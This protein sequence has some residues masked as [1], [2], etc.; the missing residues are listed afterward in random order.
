MDFYKKVTLRAVFGMLFGI[1]M[2]ASPL[3]VVVAQQGT[4][5]PGS[6]QGTYNPGSPQGTYNGDSQTLQNPLGVSSFC[7]LI[8]IILNAALIIGIPIAILFIVFAGAKF[9]L[10]R[11]NP[12]ELE[13]A[14]TNLF[15]TLIGI[16]I[17]VGASLI[18]KVII[19]TL[20][21]LGVNVGSCFGS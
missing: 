13:A 20:H 3:F 19:G 11:G 21:E 4:Y 1:A 16:A 18:A 15:N 7:D 14:R 10:A 9:V 6:P 12:G 8:A 17:F 2:F 5:N